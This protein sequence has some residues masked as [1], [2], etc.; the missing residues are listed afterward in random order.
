MTSLFWLVMNLTVREPQAIEL[1]APR[2]LSAIHVVLGLDATHNE[3]SILL[4]IG[5]HE[6]RW[7][8]F[9]TNKDGDSGET[10][11]R[12]P[13]MW[14]SS[15]DAVLGSRQEAYRVALRILRH[16]RVVCPGK[17]A[18]VLTVYVSGGCGIAP[19]KARELC[20]P[21]GLCDVTYTLDEAA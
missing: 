3:R 12:N 9:A 21:T 11:I 15:R 4:S 14:G 7:N 17:F 6:S 20:E 10:Q 13:W 5:H 19:L 16:A 8:Q 1:V 2:G 18:R